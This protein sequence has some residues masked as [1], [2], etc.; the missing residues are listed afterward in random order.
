MLHLRW[1]WTIYE[2]NNTEN[3]V[4]GVRVGVRVQVAEKRNIY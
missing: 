2:K 4:V 1:G 3:F